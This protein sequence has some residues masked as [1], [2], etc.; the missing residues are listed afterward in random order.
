MSPVRRYLHSRH[1]MRTTLL[2]ATLLG[3]SL[4]STAS[5]AIKQTELAAR[6]EHGDVE[7]QYALAQSYEQDLKLPSHEDLARIWYRKASENG[8]AASSHHLAWMLAEGRGGPADT[9]ESARLLSITALQGYGPAQ[10]SFGLLLLKG[11]G[12]FKED[13]IEACAWL[14]LARENGATA[15]G[16]ELLIPR[17][18]AD[19]Q[20]WATERASDISKLILSARERATAKLNPSTT[21][22]PA[23]A[24]T[25]NADKKPGDSTPPQPSAQE[26]ELARELAAAQT[27]AEADR[28]TI[29]R[30]KQQLEERGRE[31]AELKKDLDLA[32]QGTA[33]ALA[34]Q[35]AATQALP[36]L[37]ASQLEIDTLR[38]Q[39]RELGTRQE[40]EHKRAAEDLSAT[41]SQLLSAKETIK[42]LTEANRAFTEAR[43]TSE[44]TTRAELD[45]LKARVADLTQTLGKIREERDA[46][47]T[48]L[49][50]A[51]QALA[52]QANAVA[53]LTQA[54]VKLESERKEFVAQT[55]NLT[56][57]L[58][59][60]GLDLNATKAR[61]SAEEVR[62]KKQSEQLDE[63]GRLNEGLQ[64]ELAAS[65]LRLADSESLAQKHTGKAE[66]LGQVRT[67]LQRELDDTKGRLA[68][69][70]LKSKKQSGQLDE[71]GRL[72]D[73]LQKD[74]EA[75]AGEIKSLKA[76]NSGLASR[77]RQAQATLEQIAANSKPG[78]AGTPASINR[79][80]RT[81]TAA[82]PPPVTPAA[83]STPQRLHVVAEGDSLSKISLL[84][85]GTANRWQEI[86]EANRAQLQGESS[87]R[88]G[89]KLRIP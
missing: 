57:T 3:F 41:A 31:L 49:T 76:E 34:A 13:P 73:K 45:S 19:E 4:C 74:L 82:V 52:K 79:P 42:S 28:H 67:Q 58:E 65:R 84:Y 32:K 11:G 35:A 20:A 18:S 44:N 68:A 51:D 81:G 16:L 17:L 85:Y 33:A 55:L 62:T 30:I 69:A 8:H 72:K 70:D 25:A 7:A 14:K 86:Y 83:D 71:L 63:L 6:A 77:V 53:E 39:L 23:S 59:K 56:Q 78:S 61:V 46:S 21:P 60:T 27:S 12:G 22:P 43:S 48:R 80:A 5:D 26:S 89:Q 87:L 64:K 1:S 24:S 75:S 38:K 2:V 66:E 88:P 54:K 50:T 9:W 36:D 47:L 29:A 37:Q 15:S 10:E 40:Q